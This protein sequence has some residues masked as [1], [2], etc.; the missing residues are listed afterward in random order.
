MEHKSPASESA[1]E[2]LPLPP[3]KRGASLARLNEIKLPLWVSLALLVL[4]L[5]V[6][7]WKSFSVA[8][9]ERGVE[10]ERQA[11]IGQRT[12]AEEEARSAV[13][14][15]SDATHALFGTAL[16]WAVR[17]DMI[18]NNL[19]QIDQYFNELVK[20]ERIRLVLLADPAGKVLVSS[21]RAFVDAPL[22]PAFPASLLEV[23]DVTVQPAAAPAERQLVIPIQGLNTRLGTVILVYGMEG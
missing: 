14:R 10:A 2:P 1:P 16:A 21:D 13:L 7:A 11:L 9:V 17:G 5:L 19:D 20:A 23:P 6:F 12:A 3:R 15:T 8:T 4:L 18:R 22:P